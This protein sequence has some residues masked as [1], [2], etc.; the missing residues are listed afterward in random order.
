MRYKTI[1]GSVALALGVL[2]LVF[3]FY[4]KGRVS[5]ELGKVKKGTDV[6]QNNPLTRAGGKSAKT[7][8][9]QTSKAVNQMASDKATPYASAARWSL[10]SGIVLIVIGGAVFVVGRRKH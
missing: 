9:R 1:V 3:S 8:T 5:D 10:V 6:L 2:C 4:V 7:V